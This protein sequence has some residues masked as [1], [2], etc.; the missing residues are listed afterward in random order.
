MGIRIAW[1]ESYMFTDSSDSSSRVPL[2]RLALRR[3]S[4]RDAQKGTC[5]LAALSS[6]PSL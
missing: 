4:Q 3:D 6:R 1:A 2:L 5:S